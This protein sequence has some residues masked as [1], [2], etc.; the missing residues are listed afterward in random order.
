M[1]TR[2]CVCLCLYAYLGLGQD[3]LHEDAV[4]QGDQLAERLSSR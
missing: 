2:V 3:A 1:F 4:R